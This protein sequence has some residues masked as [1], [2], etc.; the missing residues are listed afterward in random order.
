MPGISNMGLG[1]LWAIGGYLLT[2]LTHSAASGGGT[3]V[4]FYG[5]IIAGGIQ[6]SMVMLN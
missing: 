5:A 1:A 2:A 3:Y 6:L 4:V